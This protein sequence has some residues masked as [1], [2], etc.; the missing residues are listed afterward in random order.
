MGLGLKVNVGHV[1]GLEHDLGLGVDR[2]YKPCW[3][4][5]IWARCA[6]AQASSGSLKRELVS[7][8]GSSVNNLA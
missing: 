2:S 8:A 6:F 4:H 1:L 5:I 3:D 7:L